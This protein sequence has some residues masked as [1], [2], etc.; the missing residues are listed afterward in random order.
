MYRSPARMTCD[1][2]GGGALRLKPLNFP[3]KRSSITR[4]KVYPA[5]L[6][7]FSFPWLYN[8]SFCP[9][10]QVLTFFVKYFVC[11]SSQWTFLPPKTFLVKSTR[12]FIVLF[13]VCCVST[14]EINLPTDITKVK[15]LLCTEHTCV[16]LKWKTDGFFC[17]LQCL[18]ELKEVMQK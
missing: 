12:Y 8:W 14:L 15:T 18:M 7:W 4:Q 1:V 13:F 16:L 17:R 11:F 6:M 2:E 3:F 9:S 10:K 5:E